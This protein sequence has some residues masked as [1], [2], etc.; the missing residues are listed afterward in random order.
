LV[1]ALMRVWLK[2]K[3]AALDGMKRV[4]LAPLMIA[5]VA[6]SARPKKVFASENPLNL[7]RVW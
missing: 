7:A 3:K 4:P 6:T 5:C 1:P 2:L